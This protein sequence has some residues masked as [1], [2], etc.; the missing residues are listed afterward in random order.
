[1][2]PDIASF[3]D[4]DLAVGAAEYDD[5]LHGGI[6]LKRV[7]D[8]LLKCDELATAVTPIGSDDELG[9]RIGKTILDTLGAEAAEDDAMNRPYAGTGQHSN[10]GLGDQGH[11]DEDSLP[12]FDSVA[13][14]HIGE[15]ADLAM[16]LAVGDDFFVTRLPFPDDGGLV[17]TRGVEMA[18][19]AVL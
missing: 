9:P 18:V 6:A 19:E 8:I 13:L 3:L 4:V 1:M 16:K 17:G 7:V 2:P 5:L 10:G 11:V 12:F 15:L 14:E